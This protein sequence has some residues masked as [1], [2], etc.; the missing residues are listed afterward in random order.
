MPSVGAGVQDLLEQGKVS[1]GENSLLEGAGGEGTGSA[2]FSR[3]VGG[4]A[5]RGGKA[6]EKICSYS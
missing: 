2:V 4:A 5:V 1:G 6:A 3:A